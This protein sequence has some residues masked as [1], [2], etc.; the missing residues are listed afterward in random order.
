[1]RAPVAKAPSLRNLNGMRRAFLALTVAIA[2]SGPAAAKDSLGVY[3]KW[4]AFRDA[5]TPRCYAIAKPRGN[6]PE[7]YASIA[8]WPRQGVRGQV[9]LRLSRKAQ[10]DRG[11]TLRIGDRA[12][13]L[14]VDGRNAWAQDKAM[15][16][17]IVAALRSATSMR[18]SART[19]AGRRFTDRYDLAGAATAIDAAVVGCAS[20]S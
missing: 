10:S 7:S 17:A 18:V 16:A 14:A 4:A 19:A 12:F 6:R 11:A 5:D 1:M 15:D 8:N 9:Y 3:S 13:A 20:L 2:L